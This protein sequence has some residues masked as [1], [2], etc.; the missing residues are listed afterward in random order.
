MRYRRRAAVVIA[1]VTLL[2][3]AMEF[4][5]ELLP[6]LREATNEGPGLRPTATSLLALVYAGLI[7]F[8]K[9]LIFKPTTKTWKRLLLAGLAV[10]GVILIL[11]HGFAVPL[12][13]FVLSGLTFAACLLWFDSDVRETQDVEKDFP[14]R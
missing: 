9:S 5:E 3:I 2:S 1:L 12:I 14:A 8:K 6:G 7:A 11:V 4:S 13:G 10:A